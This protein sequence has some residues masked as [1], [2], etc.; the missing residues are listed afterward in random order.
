MCEN[1]RLETIAKIIRSREESHS[2]RARISVENK[3][4]T[5]FA[6]A[7]KS[8]SDQ[9][10]GTARETRYGI[11]PNGLAKTEKSGWRISFSPWESDKKALLDTMSNEQ[12]AEKMSPFTFF[13]LGKNASLFK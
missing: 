6:R 3:R 12:S 7:V 11:A 13:G 5:R 10:N 9:R 8:G 2:S 1:V 4:R